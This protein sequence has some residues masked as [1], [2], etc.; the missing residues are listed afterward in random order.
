MF[1]KTLLF[2][3]A[4]GTLTLAGCNIYFGEGQ[5]DGSGD[6]G[7]FGCGEEPVAQPGDTCTLDVNCAPGCFCAASGV[8]EEAGFC[9][10]DL[11][12]AEGFGCEL[13][14]SSCV[15]NRGRPS[16]ESTA[17]C[18]S[19]TYCDVAFGE[20]VPSWTCRD[21]AECGV[22]WDCN[23]ANRTCEPGACTSNSECAEGC[24]C[25]EGRCVETGICES[26]AD[27]M[28]NQECDTA[29]NTCITPPISCVA[30]IDA[31][32]NEFAPFCGVGFYP[33]IQRGCYT[34]QCVAAADCDEIPQ[35]LCEELA[36]ENAC[37]AR[38]DCETLFTGINCTDPNGQSCTV[39]GA[40]CTCERFVFRSCVELASSAQ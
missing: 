31:S 20:C 10:S 32:C 17:E 5:N 16:C 27:C 11:D 30:E 18:Q 40:N 15:P 6:C 37:S 23:Q 12:C 29:R 24:N 22:G 26:D 25:E 21:D 13:E 34:G 1:R 38:A 36:T 8:C 7:L 39:A 35:P 28:N 3:I 33:G 19:G 2:L 4:A 9:E 14:R